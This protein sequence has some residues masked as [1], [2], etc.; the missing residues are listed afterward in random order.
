MSETLQFCETADLKPGDR[1][2]CKQH[3]ELVGSVRGYEWNK[4]GVLSAIP[5]N[6]G[7]DNNS[8][9]FSLRGAFAI[10]ASDDS[11][12]KIEDTA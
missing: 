1:V 10:Y 7:W 3:P 11:V 9:A 6:I 8:L 2:R 4:P 5:Y 12:E